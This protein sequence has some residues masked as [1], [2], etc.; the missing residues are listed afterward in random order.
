MQSLEN[1]VQGEVKQNQS[2]EYVVLG[3]IEDLET[4][5]AEGKKVTLDEIQGIEKELDSLTNVD[6]DM[7]YLLRHKILKVRRKSLKDK[8]Q[9]DLFCE[10]MQKYEGLKELQ[11]L[12]NFINERKDD[13]ITKEEIEELNNKFAKILEL[14]QNSEISS[15]DRDRIT[16]EINK[17]IKLFNN[18]LSR[19]IEDDFGS[20][21]KQLR[22]AKK[23]SLK[24]LEV[25]SGVTAS[26]IHRIESGSRKTPSVPVAE[27]LA[28][29]LG[30]SPDE[31]LR[32]LNLVSDDTNV[33]RNISLTELIAKNSFTINEKPVSH[34]QKNA[35]LDVMNLIL[36]FDW[37]DNT[38]LQESMQL[39]NKMDKFKET[40]KSNEQVEDNQ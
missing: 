36:D 3:K 14:I 6:N 25:L 5:I 13:A 22:K 34:E 15:Y 12:I 1:R 38:K 10:D 17:K 26:Y 2:P 9:W 18:R 7:D 23:Y 32:R 30:V 37:T 24:Q 28:I 11:E 39:I 19:V 4:K 8:T 33:D 31:F 21:V 35:L 27:K 16:R 20:W 40:F 29:G